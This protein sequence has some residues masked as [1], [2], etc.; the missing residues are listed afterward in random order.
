MINIKHVCIKLYP[1]NKRMAE[2]Q[3]LVLRKSYSQ[4]LKSFMK[5]VSWI[6]RRPGDEDDKKKIAYW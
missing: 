6:A 4:N 1:N 2:R 3:F 5:L